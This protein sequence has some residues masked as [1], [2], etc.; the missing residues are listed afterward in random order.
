MKLENKNNI[1]Q[2]LYFKVQNVIKNVKIQKY[3]EE[4]QEIAN[5][6]FSFL[7]GFTGKNSLQLE[8]IKNVKLRIELL[9]SQKIDVKE[10]YQ[11][12]DMMADLYM[13]AITE[14]GGNFTEE[15]Q[16]LYNKIKN[17]NINE[18]ISEEDV[19][20]LACKKIEESQSYLPIIHE[21]KPKGIFADTK[22]Q[23]KFYKL[24]NQKLENEIISERGKSRF[25]TFSCCNKIIPVSVNFNKNK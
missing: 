25:E 5:E 4:G 9:Q 6:K 21:E 22:V 20:K 24:E 19:Y 18:N 15:M 17:E 23:I 7:G 10:E 2:D 8:K 1:S 3:A 12:E 14:L 11:L 13:C 16:I